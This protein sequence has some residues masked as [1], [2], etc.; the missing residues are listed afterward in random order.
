VDDIDVILRYEQRSR[1][2]DRI[3]AVLDGVLSLFSKRPWPVKMLPPPN[4]LLISN[5][6]HLGDLIMTASLL[7]VLKRAFPSL[8]IGILCGTWGRAIV[9][10]NPFVDSVYYLDHWHLDRDEL[11]LWRKIF[12]YFR[13]SFIIARDI[14]VADYDTAI[15]MRPWF[16]N[17]VPIL[18]RAG[19]PIRLGYKK[20]GSTPLLTHYLDFVYDRRH[21]RD[22]Q[23]ALLRCLPIDETLLSTAG[24]KWMK[25]TESGRAEVSALLGDEAG[26]YAV[27]H[28]AGSIALKDWTEDGW[29][30]LAE[31]ILKAGLRPV[32]TGLGE[33]QAGLI[34]RIMSNRVEG[35]NLC[36]CLSWDGLAALV[37]DAEIVYCV[38]TSVGH[39][40]AALGVPCVA[41]LGGMTDP[42]QWRPSGPVAAAVSHS[43]SCNPC[44]DKRG[45]AH[46]SCLQK[47]TVD[48][49]WE[50]GNLL[51][52]K[53]AG[54]DGD[55]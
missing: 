48:E 10:G 36:G 9:H 2:Q 4:R 38:D 31:R 11:P 49:V 44:F 45:C 34:D 27:L 3:A 28:P 51:R 17:A 33:Q 39:L 55:D 16:P 7:P 52:F 47:V 25:V 20:G 26:P 32:F 37:A 46:L 50:T 41:I 21:E 40:A 18:W 54:D 43:I 53:A 24:H 22:Y 35:L 42:R 19:I 15:A 5:F 23:M 13:Q 1:K 14:R 30:Q 6:G 12:A 29:R 8:R